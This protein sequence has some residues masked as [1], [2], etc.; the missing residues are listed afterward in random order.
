MTALVIPHAK[1]VLGLRLLLLSLGAVI[2]VLP[3]AWLV[4]TS[5][6][7]DSL[8]LQVPP[9]LLPHH[10]TTDNYVN[11]WKSDQFGHYFLNSVMVSVASTFAAVLLAAMMASWLVSFSEN[12]C[13][14][15]I[16][17]ISALS[18]V[19]ICFGTPPVVNTPNQPPIS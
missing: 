2:M 4:S 8:V 14:R 5:L 10:I 18:L 12:S 11:A 6:K 13:S 3:F 16:A 15:R 17:T 19:T 7:P 1:R 9:Q